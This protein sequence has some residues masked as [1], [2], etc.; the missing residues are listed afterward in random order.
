MLTFI[1]SCV[2]IIASFIT[3][4]VLIGHSD[5]DVSMS[6]SGGLSIGLG[7]VLVIYFLTSALIPTGICKTE[8]YYSVCNVESQGLVLHNVVK[9]TYAVRA[10]GFLN[11]VSSTTE[12]TSSKQLISESS[13]VE[14][15]KLLT[16]NGVNNKIDTGVVDKG[17]P[18]AIKIIL[19]II[20]VLVITIA[21]RLNRSRNF[22][23]ALKSFNG[24]AY[25]EDENRVYS[26]HE[27]EG[28]RSYGDAPFSTFFTSKGLTKLKLTEE[29]NK[30]NK[31]G[32]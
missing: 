9:Y 23:V 8:T 13:R 26:R 31:L 24:W 30:L 16:S 21:L 19:G 28:F 1:I 6:K 22:I 20:I 14:A 12:N 3:G 27:I 2:I 11:Y 17:S 18:L 15:E 10:L 7:A 4:I 25:T 32:L 5:K 29:E